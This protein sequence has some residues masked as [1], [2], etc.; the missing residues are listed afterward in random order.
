MDE[1]LHQL[2]YEDL[3]HII[4][5]IYA[6][7][8]V[9]KNFKATNFILKSK[10]SYSQICSKYRITALMSYIQKLILSKLDAGNKPKLDDIEENF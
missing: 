2:M 10:I 6:D 8:I 3:L 5:S 7:H 4:N 1:N 9:A